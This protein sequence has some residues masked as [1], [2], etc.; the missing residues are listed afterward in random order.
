MACSV[1]WRKNQA[2][3][4][5]AGVGKS[6]I[7]AVA[8]MIAL[9]RH[10]VSKVHILVPNVQ[11]KQRE[12]HDFEDLFKSANVKDKVHYYSNLDFEADKSDLIVVDEA[13]WFINDNP[14][15]FFNAMPKS[16]TKI[17]LSGSMTSDAITEK[18]MDT[19]EKDVLRLLQYSFYDLTDAIKNCLLYTSPSPRDS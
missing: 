6:R 11:L 12:E 4:L 16:V 13:D 14:E 8:A 3:T 19:C 17:L 15:V 18:H 7:I 9:S 1:P 10:L 5:Q 2:W